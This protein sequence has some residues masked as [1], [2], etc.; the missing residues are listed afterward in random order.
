[1]PVAVSYPGVYIQ[2]IPSGVRTITGVATSITAFIGRAPRGT[3]SEPVTINSY[4]DFE[5]AFGGLQVSYPMSYSVRDFYLN[6]GSQAIIVRLDH[7]GVTAHIPLPTGAAAPND[8]LTLVAAS[9]G[10]WGNNLSATVDYLTMDP[11]NVNLFNLTVS[12]AGGST[13]K[14]LNLSINS[15]DARYAPRVLQQ[16]S[17]LVRVATD[18]TTHAWIVPNVRPTAATTPAA[19]N[20]GVD[21]QPLV[22][23]DYEGSQA[24]KTGIY[25]LEKADLFTLLCIPPDVRG[26]DTSPA[27]YQAAMAYCV[28]RRAVLIVDPPAA[29]SQPKETAAATALAGLSAHGLTGQAARNAGLYFPRLIEV[30]PNHNG[31][32]DVFAASGALAGI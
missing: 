18:P 8:V 21:G 4:G 27:V 19:S 15:A 31:Q 5:R 17:V 22:S 12:E 26:G 14:F 9:P 6:G 7:G 28:T 2:E 32:S 16:S 23:T 13:E 24:N 1:M 10:A 11:T 30:D 3:V 20:S 25:A 29:W